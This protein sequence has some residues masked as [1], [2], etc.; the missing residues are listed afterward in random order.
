MRSTS[1]DD[2]FTAIAHPVRRSLL[3]SLASG[4]Q[5][6]NQ[7]A[8][9]YHVSRPAI[10]QHLRILLEAGLVEGRRD[11]RVNNYLL[12]PERLAE[13]T[14]W[15]RKYEAFWQDRLVRLG[16]Y[17]D[18]TAQSQPRSRQVKTRKARRKS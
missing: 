18:R 13:V 8:R 12:R 16:R 1:R 6:V 2:V 15:L 3:D 7:L 9:R 5:P 17:L 4:A 14:D 10:S 11:G